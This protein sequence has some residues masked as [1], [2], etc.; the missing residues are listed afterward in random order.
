MYQ[1][2]TIVAPATAAGAAAIAVIRLSGPDS[3][4]ILHA[5][6]SPDR[7][8]ELTP[9]RLR[10]GQIR[11]P[12]SRV[13]LDRAM[14]VVM[15][16]P[17]SFTGEDV[18]ELQCHGGPYLVRRVVALAI[19]QGAR[20]A[21]PGEFTRRAFLNGRIDLTEAEAIADLISARSDSAL[22]QALDQL[23]GALSDR[24]L[25]LRRQLIAIRAHLEAEIDFSDEDLA[26]PPR[27]QIT[28]SIGSLLAD[29]RVLH[30]S[31]ERG[32]IV[33]DGARAAIIGKPNVG[34]S[35]IMN[36]MLGCDRAIVTPHPGTTRD[37]I[38]DSAALDPYTLVI[39]DTAGLRPSADP[40]ERIGIGLA[41]AR[42]ADCDLILAVFD[43]SRPLDEDDA[44]VIGASRGRS[45]LAIL[46]KRDLPP[47]FCADDLRAAGTELRVLSLSAL[48]P[49][50]T[51]RLKNE[52]CRI[53]ET[54]AEPTEGES[55]QIS[56]SR[57]R[58]S[59]ARA[60]ASL[61]E[62]HESAAAGLPLEIVA[63]DICAAADSLA[64]ITGSITTDDVLDS[65]F[66]DF[67]IGK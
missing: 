26:L 67:C 4:R 9:R 57:H 31:F 43:S 38:E 48:D 18:V 44:C 17:A 8:A 32:R 3:F 54:I 63:V 33:R 36:L 41:L 37:V 25:D 16:A 59:L 51:P 11:D 65:I 15:P 47:V 66:R 35:S 52:L 19:A 21:D 20:L 50:D 12:G 23:G 58:D 39:Q 60:M 13:R 56:R 45:G 61:T 40:V 49:A 6:W 29:I 2:D 22:R 14:A 10:L 42:A 24:V 27:D 55:L 34:K 46:N 53:L 5:I 1:Q 28:R 62:A 7:G 64:Q 30:D